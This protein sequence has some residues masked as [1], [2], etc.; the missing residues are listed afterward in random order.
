MSNVKLLGIGSF[1]NGGEVDQ[2]GSSLGNCDS[3]FRV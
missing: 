3:C 2:A 1:P